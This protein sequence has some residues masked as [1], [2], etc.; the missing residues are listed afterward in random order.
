M[1]GNM[2]SILFS[3]VISFL[4]G[5]TGAAFFYVVNPF[6]NSSETQLE[7]VPEYG[8][9]ARNA[10]ITSGMAV[11]EDFVEASKLSTQ[12]VVFIKTTSESR[13]YD[14]F[15][16]F[17]F[18]FGDGPRNRN[19]SGAGSG[20]IFT[21][22]GYIVTNNHVVEDADKIEVI[23]QKRSYQAAVI[24][25]DPSSDL[26]ILKI[27]AN[28]LPNI[29]LGSSRDLEVGE[30][31]IAVG[32]PFNLTSTVTAG[33]VSAK[34]RDI[35]LL[36]GQ[37]PLE[38]FIQTDAAI[39]P[40]NSGGA[41]INVAGEL[42][43]INTAILSRTGSYTGYG[44]AVPV[45]IVAKIFNDIIQFGGVQKAFAGVEVSDLN[46]QIAKQF[47]IDSDS[48]DGAII[49]GVQKESAAETSGLEA[50][51]VIKKINEE[52]VTSK[53][54]YEELIS[55]YRPG[56]N[57]QVT[58]ER[59]GTENTISL[60]LENRQGTTDILESEVYKSDFLGADLEPLSKVE[61]EQL[62]IDYGVRILKI[63]GG[64]FS[65]MRL[66]EG[67]VI[68]SINQQETKTAEDVESILESAGGRVTIE[69]ISSDGR[70][71]YYQFYF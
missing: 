69:G 44:F 34:G 23:H 57:I 20:V 51:D 10:S 52:P 24:G 45:D 36:S 38:S 3:I 53:S 35:Q 67:F 29:K 33:I 60:T 4:S 26:A 50:G 30:W 8:K 17:D 42:V 19:I 1:N 55:Y 28:D 64:L 18:Y 65:R 46:T 68:L 43:G 2:K 5:I 11:N 62:G 49:T 41:L 15:D 70:Q 31:V 32:N 58:Y 12:S 63:R 25:T 71:G 21:S 48:Y 61:R 13:Y 27:D 47:E 9:N 6:S 54:T 7:I 22:D 14:E 40:G 66:Q 59:N 39:N 16:L 37:F 56:E